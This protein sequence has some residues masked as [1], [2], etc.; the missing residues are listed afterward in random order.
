MGSITPS[1][2]VPQPENQ[3]EEKHKVVCDSEAHRPGMWLPEHFQTRD[4]YVRQVLQEA[5]SS[6]QMLS[7]ALR[8]FEDLIEKDSRI[9]MYFMQM[10]EEIPCQHPCWKEPTGGG[11]IG[12]YKHMLHVLNYIVT[13]APSWSFPAFLDPD[14]NKCVKEVLNEW[15]SFLQS[16]SSTHV[17]DSGKTGWL[18]PEALKALT[19]AANIP[20]QAELSFE[21][22]Y[23][24]DSSAVHYGFK[25]W[26][27][28]FTRKIRDSARPVACPDN[29]NVI[30]HPCE[31]SVYNIQRN[32]KLRDNF[33][34]KGQPYSIQDILAHEPLTSYFA[35]GTV[36][37][38]FLSAL[39][40]HRW[41]SPVSG[42]VRRAFVQDG[43]YFSLPTFLGVGTLEDIPDRMIPAQGYLAAVAARAI[44]IIEADNREIGLVAFVAID[45]E[46][47]ESVAVRGKLG[48]KLFDKGER[49]EHPKIDNNGHRPLDKANTT[50]RI[51]PCL[52][53]TFTDIICGSGYGKRSEVEPRVCRPTR[54]R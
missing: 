48:T 29:D 42:I 43:A 20:G 12:D 33:F 53:P 24:C 40:Y 54:S 49:E 39:A 41:H 21:E 35:Q 17:L 47:E 25:S 5:N 38:A 10:F 15:S 7:P 46:R 32:V 13:N 30:V 51:Y 37:Q 27:D 36:Y 19:D 14:V 8:R 50:N 2:V 52:N 26:D 45:V 3:I 9:Y 23:I 18:S 22:V 31:S 44:I 34:A 11:R 16:P 4:E 6:H 1:Q 28:F